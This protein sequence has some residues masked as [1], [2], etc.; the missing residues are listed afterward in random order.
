MKVRVN[1]A[2]SSERKKFYS[3]KEIIDTIY[4][5]WLHP[6]VRVCLNKRKRK[7]LFIYKF[8]FHYN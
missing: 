3:Y 8:N 4:I 6:L 2:L 5:I 1:R 7:F